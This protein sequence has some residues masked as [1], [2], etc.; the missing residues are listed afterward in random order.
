MNAIDKNSG[1]VDRAVGTIV[2]ATLFLALGSTRISAQEKPPATP[3]PDKEAGTKSDVPEPG[4]YNNSLTLG[5]G[6]FFV[7]GD[8]AA[9]MRRTQMPAGTFGGV[10]ELHFEEMVGKKGLFQLDARSIWDNRDNLFKVDLSH[11]EIGYVRAGYKEFRTWYDGSGGFSP[12]SNAWVTLYDEEL[13]IDR[14]QAWFEGGLTLPD[15]PVFTVR[16]T[17]D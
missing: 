6:H 11:P 10:E 16:Y 2:I 5:V 8:K 13:H 4:E 7:D 9:F 14:R 12:R 17:S 1:R 15:W 3:T